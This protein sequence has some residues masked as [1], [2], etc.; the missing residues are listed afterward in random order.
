MDRRG[1]GQDG[2]KEPTRRAPSDDRPDVRA[3]P[4]PDSPRG[5][6]RPRASRRS[7]APAQRAGQ[8]STATSGLVRRAPQ[9]AEH[10]L[11]RHQ[12][13]DRARRGADRDIRARLRRRHAAQPLTARDRRTVG[14]LEAMSRAA[15]T[16]GWACA[17]LD[18]N[19]MYA[20]RRVPASADRFPEDVLELQ[21]Y[22]NGSSR[23]GRRRACR[24][25]LERTPVHP[26]VLA[27]RRPA[28]AALVCRMRRQ[29]LRRTNARGGCGDLDRS[30]FKPSAQLDRR[31]SS[32]VST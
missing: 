27:V 28:A 23:V 10:R 31:T 30:E 7:V 18:Q 26:G 29:P 25:G 17:R 2:R 22:L 21:A 8:G 14:T 12:R 13:A 3:R 4:G 32:P 24:Q 15:S 11:A 16:S 1:Q 19:T 6:A 5:A 9:H 20:L